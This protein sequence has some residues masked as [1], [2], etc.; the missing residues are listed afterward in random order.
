MTRHYHAQ[1]FNQGYPARTIALAD[2]LR[3][4]VEQL[5]LLVKT[6]A[7]LVRE[8]FRYGDITRTTRMGASRF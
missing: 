1:M 5:D 4:R 7:V 3:T 2:E 8:N 6:V